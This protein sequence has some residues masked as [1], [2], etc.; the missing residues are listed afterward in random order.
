MDLH[1]TH[2]VKDRFFGAVYRGKNLSIPLIVEID[3]KC[4][5]A[6]KLC[7]GFGKNVMHWVNTQTA[8]QTVTSTRSFQHEQDIYLPFEIIQIL[9]EW[10][11]PPIKKRDI[12]YVSTN[13]ELE[14]ENKYVVSTVPT[15]EL[16]RNTSQVF[17][18]YFY[19]LICNTDEADAIE[20]LLH[21]RLSGFRV[22]CMTY[23]IHLTDLLELTGQ[24]IQSY[25]AM[26]QFI[27]DRIETYN[28]NL[29]APFD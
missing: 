13:L 24:V 12:L 2:H 29:D 14:R 17:P 11:A 7:T 19:L 8:V 25:Q 3:K 4:F 20:S 6:T 15:D 21:R 1:T 28:R 16:A 23:K 18:G 26:H 27:D 22:D 10:I 9:L 5:N